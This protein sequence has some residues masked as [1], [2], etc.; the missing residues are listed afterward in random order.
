MEMNKVEVDPLWEEKECG[1]NGIM[2]EKNLYTDAD[3]LPSY[4]GISISKSDQWSIIPTQYN[5]KIN[6]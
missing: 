5:S 4:H 2:Q 1:E 6:R 3:P